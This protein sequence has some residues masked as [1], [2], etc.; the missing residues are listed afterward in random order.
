MVQHLRPRS[1][2]S[3]FKFNSSVDCGKQVH[4]GT[5]NSSLAIPLYRTRTAKLNRYS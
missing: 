1:P 4:F 3:K 5:I 2:G